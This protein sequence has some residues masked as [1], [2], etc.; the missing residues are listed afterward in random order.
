MTPITESLAEHAE[1]YNE[2]VSKQRSLSDLLDEAVQTIV[3]TMAVKIGLARQQSDLQTIGVGHQVPECLPSVIR[4]GL[5]GWY[6]EASGLRIERDATQD[7]RYELPEDEQRRRIGITIA[8][9]HGTPTVIHHNPNQGGI[10]MITG[11]VMAGRADGYL[12]R[13]RQEHSSW[14]IPFQEVLQAA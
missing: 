10:Q 12:A 13:V 9:G 5:A 7:H 4:E 6:P 8:D 3:Q 1:Q 11:N 14:E 2:F